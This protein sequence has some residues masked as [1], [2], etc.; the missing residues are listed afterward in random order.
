MASFGAVVVLTSELRIANLSTTEASLVQ[1]VNRARDLFAFLSAVAFVLQGFLT[2]AARA[3]V[4]FL[5]AGVDSAVQRPFTRGIAKNLVLL[6]ALHRFGGPSTAATSLDHRLTR[7]TR[8]G[9]TKLGTSMLTTLYP[10]AKIPTGMS[11]VTSVKLGILFLTTEAVVFPWNLLGHVLAG[12]TTPP[13]V[14]F[15]TAGPFGRTGQVQ[16]VVAIRTGPNGLCRSHQVATDE[17]FQ[18]AGIQLP[19]EFLPLRA[20]GDDFRFQ[21]LLAGSVPL[22]SIWPT[23]V[24]PFRLLRRSIVV[25]V[26][27]IVAVV[28]GIVPVMIRRLLTASVAKTSTSSVS[29]PSSILLR[30]LLVLLLLLLRCPTGSV[31]IPR[32]ATSTQSIVG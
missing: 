4:A 6:A 10:A 32:K 19:D 16:N 25:V 30:L 11:H 8:P 18:L 14:G 26:I 5:L 31:E 13:V 24:F 15:R 12:R 27:V 21:L 28:L 2:F 3:A 20:L 7:W 1:V 9:M 23:V 17:A 29:L 22:V